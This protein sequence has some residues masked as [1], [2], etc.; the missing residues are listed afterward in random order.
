[1]LPRRWRKRVGKPTASALQSKATALRSN[2][3][4]VIVGKGEVVELALT[5]LLARGHVLIEDVPGLGKTLLAR[6]L[7]RSIDGRFQRVQFT[8]DLL[9]S[10]VT[11]TAVYNERDRTFEFRPGPVFANIFLG[12]ELNRATPR[13]QSSLLEAMEERQVTADGQTHPLPSLFFVIATQNPVEQQGVY[14]LPEAQLDRFLMRLSVGYP[15]QA[16]EEEIV[17]AQLAAQP[18]ATLEPVASVD[19]VLALQQEVRC[20][21]V[22]ETILSYVVSLVA[23]TRRHGD[24][25]LGASPRA[26]LGLTVAAQALAYLEGSRFVLPDHIKRLAVPVLAHRLILKPQSILAGVSAATII[27][28]LLGQVPV[29]L[30]IV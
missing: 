6:A 30:S 2:I 18:L 28:D 25:V 26:S 11:G 14:P 13:T 22:D 27:L 21:H 16:D 20:V 8:P 9:P 15:E 24:L 17:R 29:P 19:D 4:R 3:G 1:M 23:A 12:D 10:D 5:A 7:A